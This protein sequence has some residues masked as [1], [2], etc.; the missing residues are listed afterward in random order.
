MTGCLPRLQ[1]VRHINAMTDTEKPQNTD[2][3]PAA[4]PTEPLPGNWKPALGLFLFLVVVTVTIAT[5]A[6]IVDR[7]IYG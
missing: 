4:R 6:V 1:W 3:E 7:A 5:V 2:Q